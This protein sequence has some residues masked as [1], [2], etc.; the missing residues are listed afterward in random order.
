MLLQAG[1]FQQEAG[2]AVGQIDQSERA[3][4]RLF[5]MMFFQPQCLFVECDA[6]FQVGDIDIKMVEFDYLQ[7]TVCVCGHLTIA[8]R[9][10]PTYVRGIPSIVA[11]EGSFLHSRMTVGSVCPVG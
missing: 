10:S 5:P 2:T 11:G 3:V 8:F 6:T 1:Q 4:G 7:F 9:I